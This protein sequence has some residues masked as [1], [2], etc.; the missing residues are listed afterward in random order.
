MSGLKDAWTRLQTV[1]FPVLQHLLPVLCVSMKILSHDSAKNK[2]VNGFQILHFHSSFL[3][4]IM[5]VKGLIVSKEALSGGNE[6]PG[7]RGRVR[8]YLKLHCAC[9][10]T[11]QHT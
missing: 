8:Q 7:G 6:I 9:V 5:A 11:A 3:N 4:G 2:T 1:Y 10:R